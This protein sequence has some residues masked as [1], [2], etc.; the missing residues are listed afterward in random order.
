MS[1]ILNDINKK[2]ISEGMPCS[3]DSENAVLS[4][5]IND[6]TAL[7]IL[8][9]NHIENSHFH[10]T[11]SKNIFTECKNLVDDGYNIDAQAVI[12]KL[13]QKYGE[14]KIREIVLELFEANY[15]MQDFQIHLHNLKLYHYKRDIIIQGY[16]MIKS[17]YT[18][19]LKIPI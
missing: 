3:I 5:L 1:K 17:A 19:N 12:E 18:N 16:K 10:S 6:K 13:R 15:L 4:I 9:E 14:K 11:I 2:L 8:T 7:E